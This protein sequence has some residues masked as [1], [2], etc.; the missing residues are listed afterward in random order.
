MDVIQATDPARNSPR[1]QDGLQANHSRPHPPLFSTPPQAS[2]TVRVFGGPTITNIGNDPITLS[3]QMATATGLACLAGEQGIGLYS[4]ISYLW[5]Q[6]TDRVLTKR[7]TTLLRS[8]RERGGIDSPILR[9]GSLLIFDTASFHSDLADW[10][11]W[12]E[13]GRIDSAHS[14]LKRGVCPLYPTELTAEGEAFLTTKAREVFATFESAAVKNLDRAALRADWGEVTRISEMLNEVIPEKRQYLSTLINGLKRTGR[15]FAARL[16]SE[17]SAFVPSPPSVTSPDDYGTPKSTLFRINSASAVAG[18]HTSPSEPLIGRHREFKALVQLLDGSDAEG[19]RLCVIDGVVGSGKTRLLI[20]ISNFAAGLGLAVLSLHFRASSQEDGDG[21]GQEPFVVGTSRNCELGTPCITR[22]A[23]AFTASDESEA[24]DPSEFLEVCKALSCGRPLLLCL[25]DIDSLPTSRARITQILAAAM[26]VSD[27]T[28]IASATEITLG[29]VG[30]LSYAMTYL[31]LCPLDISSRYCISERIYGG[32]IPQDLRDELK[33]PAF[34]SP[35]FVVALTRQVLEE[36]RGSGAPNPSRLKMPRS[37]YLYVKYRLAQH[38]P[39]V[40]DLAEILACA[41]HE[42]SIEEL[43]TISG[44]SEA[45]LYPALTSL[46]R[47]N[48]IRSS[49]EGIGIHSRRIREMLEQAIVPSRRA[50]Y[51]LA[52]A[53]SHGRV[54]QSPVRSPSRHSIERAEYQLLL[55]HIDEARKT[56]MRAN[57]GDFNGHDFL[58]RELEVLSRIHQT[59]QFRDP[60]IQVR[61]GR[62]LS[63]LGH[64]ARA[65]YWFSRASMSFRLQGD[66]RKSSGCQ[67]F[68]LQV[69]MDDPDTDL[70]EIHAIAQELCDRAQQFGWLDI[71]N[72]VTET[73]LRAYEHNSD[74]AGIR[75]LQERTLDSAWIVGRR[76]GSSNPY[77]PLYALSLLCQVHV[78]TQEAWEGVMTLHAAMRSSNRWLF[79]RRLGSLVHAV[80]VM[81]GRDQSSEGQ[82]LLQSLPKPVST[83]SPERSDILATMNASVSLLNSWSYEAAVDALGAILRDQHSEPRGHH[84]GLVHLNLSIGLFRTGDID[85]SRRHLSEAIRL[86]GPKPSGAARSAVAALSGLLALEDGNFRKASEASGHLD[87]VPKECPYDPVLPSELIGRLHWCSGLRD[88]AIT[89]LQ[90]RLD[91]VALDPISR[92]SIARILSGF[93]FRMGRKE[94]GNN[95]LRIASRIAKTQSLSHIYPKII[96]LIRP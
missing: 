25:D 38:D 70:S 60:E 88:E 30:H 59:H 45:L 13:S 5:P 52:L 73:R 86:L 93:L 72:S 42:V 48:L 7:L 34:G 24:Y 51:H 39:L 2:L 16:K 77:P 91:G 63:Q 81:L 8:F 37:L 17:T 53:A 62:N 29:E 11:S 32:S 75:S 43:T 4:F 31:P 49:S 35:G 44:A 71:A 9:K 12:L 89:I 41:R 67:A 47:L 27:I 14:L 66:T 92:I 84:V 46:E 80:L 18:A 23:R 82:I 79:D 69:A 10:Y 26:T 76:S 50:S 78:N 40:R 22:L 6:G 74:V 56:I 19:R 57:R 64:P 15:P 65:R 36:P 85:A 87:T 54:R 83:V 96:N 55:G 68:A 33:D 94:E 90:A 58:T 95:V 28:V 21:S 1:T 20:E 61:I 3:P